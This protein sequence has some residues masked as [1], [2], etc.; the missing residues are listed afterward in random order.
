MVL[1]R[2]WKFRH[3]IRL[4][5]GAKPA[6]TLHSPSPRKT[7]LLAIIRATPTS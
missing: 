1:V 4:L 2:Y 3:T 7:L 5:K 6:V